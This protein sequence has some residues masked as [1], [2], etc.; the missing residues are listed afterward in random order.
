MRRGGTVRGIFAGFLGLVALHAV[1]QKGG[2]GRVASAFGDVAAIVERVLDKDVPAIPD[3]RN[4]GA[5]TGRNAK[6]AEAQAAGG[7][8]GTTSGRFNDRLPIPA[9]P[10]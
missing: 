7:S 6:V 1:A 9:V 3:K 4:P 2:S 8:T 5:D 10:N